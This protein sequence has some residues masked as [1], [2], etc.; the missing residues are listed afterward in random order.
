MLFINLFIFD[1]ETNVITA[2]QRKVDNETTLKKGLDTLH[3]HFGGIHKI[4]FQI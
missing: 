1:Y 4:L 3:Y 2:N